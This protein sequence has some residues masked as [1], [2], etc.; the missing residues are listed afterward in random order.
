M[1]ALAKLHQP[2]LP[3]LSA[4][5]AGKTS[6]RKRLIENVQ[7]PAL[8]DWAKSYP[9][10]LE[11]FTVH[12]D[13]EKP[14]GAYTRLFEFWST[15]PV[16]YQG[17]QPRVEVPELELE[18]LPVLHRVFEHAGRRYYLEIHP[19]RLDAPKGRKGKP[20]RQPFRE[21]YPGP[22]EELIQDTLIKMLAEDQGAFMETA[23]KKP[24]AGVV[25]TLYALRQRLRKAGHTFSYGELRD[26]LSICRRTT[27][28]IRD[29]NGQTLLDSSLLA[30]LGLSTG[31]DTNCFALFN[32]LVTRALE[33]GGWRLLNYDTS[34][35][36]RR[37]MSRWLYKRLAVRYRQAAPDQPYSFWLTTMLRDSGAGSY[38]NFRKQVRDFEL[39]LA[40]LEARN[41][42]RSN[43]R[44]L[45]TVTHA[46]NSPR[47]IQ[48]VK[49]HLTAT[50]EFRQEIMRGNFLQARVRR[51][52]P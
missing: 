29:A 26:A 24:S 44:V 10:Q 15:I 9:T 48:D 1:T 46:P 40:E 8:S 36:L 38:G 42:I 7:D 33:S 6:I 49:Y 11:L 18:G 31:Q 45:K 34:M 22:R 37:F 35:R 47:K 17:K 50:E 2:S 12:S 28:V 52:L 51:Q 32:P 23:K 13:I 14:A 19:A 30:G 43:W 41:V 21:Y 5:K 25:F 20:P 16:F 4:P 39:A 3:G 27:V